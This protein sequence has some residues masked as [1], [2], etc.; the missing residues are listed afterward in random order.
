M[1]FLGRAAER[2]DVDD[3]GNPSKGAAHLPILD[4]LEF[5]QADAR[6]SGELIAV[7]LRNGPPRRQRRLDAR[8][9]FHRC[10]AIEDFLT[11][12]ENIGAE[13][14]IHL[15]VAQTENRQRADVGQARHAGERDLHRDRDLPFDLFGR[16]PRILG[17]QLDHWWRRVRIGDD[18][19]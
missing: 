17:D 4:G 3:A 6:F 18:V 7:N 5:R 19:Q 9:K 1:V 2:R 16:P 13:I 11:V 10:Q 8:W 14:K 15:D 12:A